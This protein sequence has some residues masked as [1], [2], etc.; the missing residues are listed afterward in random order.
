MEITNY[1][2]KMLLFWLND[3][4]SE[5]NQNYSNYSE[6]LLLFRLN[7]ERLIMEKIRV[8][9]K[10]DFKAKKDLFSFFKL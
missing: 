3:D 5:I 8:A 4:Y 7:E 1:S 10:T 9:N 2:E 6:K